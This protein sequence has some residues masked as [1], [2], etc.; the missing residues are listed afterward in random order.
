MAWQNKS[1]RIVPSDWHRRKTAIHR[2][3]Q[4]VCHVCKHEGADEVDHIVNVAA[5]LRE[6]RDGDPHDLS[7][8]ALIHGAACGTCGKRCH[9]AKTAVESHVNR[10]RRNR[11]VAK[12]PGLL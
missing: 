6:Q 4:G 5:W 2:R 10:R 1:N 9:I 12:H 8:L 11:P 3:D 7:N